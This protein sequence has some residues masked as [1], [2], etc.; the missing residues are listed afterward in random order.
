MRLYHFTYLRYLERCGTIFKDGLKRECGVF[1]GA[2][3]DVI[4]LTSEAQPAMMWTK[5]GDRDCRI[6]VVFPSFDER[7]VKWDKCPIAGAPTP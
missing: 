4:W 5:G 3:H 1:N 2:P 7:L 6:T